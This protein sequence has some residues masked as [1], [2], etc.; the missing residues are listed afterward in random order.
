MMCDPE[1]PSVSN[2]A[3]NIMVSVGEPSKLVSGAVLTSILLETI[4]RK[5]K[6]KDFRV[7]DRIPPLVEVDHR[8][9][10]EVGLALKL[11]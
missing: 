7:L 8:E 2:V 6:K 1:S 9:I 11:R 4:R 3:G 10:L 5:L